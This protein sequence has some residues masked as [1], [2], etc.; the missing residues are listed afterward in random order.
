MIDDNFIDLSEEDEESEIGQELFEHHRIVVDPGQGLVRIDK[1]LMAR[2][3]NSTRNKMQQGIDNKQ[4][5]VNEL[6][7]KASYLVKPNDVIT[8]SVVA[9]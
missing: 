7:I 2:I 4:I 1:I 6:P 8:I 5:L 9:Y 3:P